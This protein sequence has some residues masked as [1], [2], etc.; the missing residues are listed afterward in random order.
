MRG[1]AIA[2]GV[3]V[4]LALSTAAASGAATSG[5]PPGV[6]PDAVKIGFIT[7]KSGPA[8]STSGNSDAGCKARV[9][10]ANAA[11]GVNG[12]KVDV[13]YVDDQTTSNLPQAQSLVDNDHVFAVVNDSALAF[14]SYRW[15][16]DHDVPL[17]GGGFDGNYYGAPG[18]EKVISA[19]GNSPPIAGIQTTL[20]PKIMKALGGT[21]VAA[22]GYGSSPSSVENVK[23]FMQYAV[24][25]VGLDPVYTNTSI[26]FGTADVG[27]LALGIKNAGADSAY[28]V[29]DLATNLALAQTLRQNG[30]KMK[31][32]IMATGYGQA[33]LDQPASKSL[34][35]EVVLISIWA[36]V[37]IKSKATERF[38]ADLKK[39]TGYTGVPDF[40]VYTGYIACDLAI[41]GLQ[42]QGDHLDQTTFAADLRS[43]GQFNPG[44][45]LGC[46]NANLSLETY[47]KLAAASGREQR[48]CQ[49]AMQVK[50][51]KFVLL[52]PKGG[53]TSYWT[54]DLIPESV[55]PEYRVT[56]TTSQK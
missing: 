56:T 54:G 28:D 49:W 35:P 5:P 43:V 38:Q 50:N 16:L 53:K 52:E 31:A 19:F 45:G 2:L 3:S 29:M 32:E 7:S 44:G 22:L 11:G 37:E 48:A 24:P 27:P 10:R 4:A 26:D 41:L 9:G 30:V 17:I 8:S 13:V 39:Y 25:A 6:T 42:Q 40:G 51:G 46:A 20:M 55:P 21:K 12:R 23:S 34:G 1:V 18:N 33:L 14:L 15:L 47:G 36:P